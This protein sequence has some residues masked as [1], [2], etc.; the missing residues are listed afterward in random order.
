M[1]QE[2]RLI[3]RIKYIPK[4][5]KAMKYAFVKYKR[6]IKLQLLNNLN[7]YVKYSMSQLIPHLKFV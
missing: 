6:K 3:W 4:I 1:F 5:H 7:H 2:I